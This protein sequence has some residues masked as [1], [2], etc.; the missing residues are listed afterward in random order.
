[1]RGY[2][3]TPSD[4][5]RRGREGTVRV[6]RCMVYGVWDGERYDRAVKA[7]KSGWREKGGGEESGE[8]R[9]GQDSTVTATIS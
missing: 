7:G 6:A 2:V 9:C 4:G 1:M 5:W 8:G 3:R